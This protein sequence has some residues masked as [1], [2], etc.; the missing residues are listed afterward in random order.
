MSSCKEKCQLSQMDYGELK[1]KTLG[2]LF[3][4]KRIDCVSRADLSTHRL[5]KNPRLSGDIS[6]KP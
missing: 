6:T 5:T 2:E 4:A 3:E 1:K